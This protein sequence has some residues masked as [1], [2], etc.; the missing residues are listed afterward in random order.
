M[1]L[2]GSFEINGD[3]TSEDLRITVVSEKDVGSNYCIQVI[4][5]TSPVYATEMSDLSFEGGL[6]SLTLSD[7]SDYSEAFVRILMKSDAG[8]LSNDYGH[9]IVKRGVAA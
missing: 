3:W 4:F 7:V 1:E 2:P 5:N 8:R 9:L 6:A